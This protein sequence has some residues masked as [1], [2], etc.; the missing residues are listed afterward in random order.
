MDRFKCECGSIVLK[1]HKARHIKTK[2]HREF[3]D[4]KK[5]SKKKIERLNE[6]DNN[7]RG[8]VEILK[9]QNN[10]EAIKAILPLVGN[11][12]RETYY[13]EQ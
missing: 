13:L 4:G 11:I 9:Q 5:Q 12:L 8:I 1:G 6:I 7:A 2:K 10:D 3:V